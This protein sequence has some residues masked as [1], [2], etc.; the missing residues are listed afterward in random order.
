MAPEHSILFSVLGCSSLFVAVFFRKRQHL[1]LLEK[2]LLQLR[3][4]PFLRKTFVSLEEAIRRLLPIWALHLPCSLARLLEVY[5][6]Q[7]IAK[8]REEIQPTT[9]CIEPL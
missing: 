3:A 1:N 5:R 6:F 8:A 7:T 9:H 4:R 2:E